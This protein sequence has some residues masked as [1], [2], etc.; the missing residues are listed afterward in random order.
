MHCMTPTTDTS[1]FTWQNGWLCGAQH[2]PSPNFGPRPAGET[3]SLAVL[4]SISLPPGEYGTGCVQQLFTNQLNWDAHP[5]FQGIRG[6]EVSAHF[7]IT[8]QGVVWQFV[9]CDDRAW[10]AGASQWCGRDNCNDF[11]IGIELEGLEGR[12]FAPPQYQALQQLCQA[13]AAHYPLTH[14]AGHEHIAPG[15]K[16]DPGPGFD[17]TRLQQPLQHLPMQWPLSVQPAKG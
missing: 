17:W 9:S 10:H 6:L 2:L 15:R 14:I 7:F 11:S 13:L 8:R 12:Q 16:Q 3:I 1:T 5:Y 4:H